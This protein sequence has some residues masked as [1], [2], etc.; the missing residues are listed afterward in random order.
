MDKTRD[1]KLYA[2]HPHSCS[3]LPDHEAT[4]V[5]VDP[6]LSIDREIYSQLS[7]FGFRR[8]GEHLY[9][10]RCQSCQACIAARIPVDFFTPNRQQ[11]RCW[12]RNQ[13]IQVEL[14]STIF[15]D[16]HYQLYA[17]YISGRHA[18]GDMYPPTRHQYE[19]FLMPA[20][21]STRY[22]EMRLE[23]KLLGV[24][25]CDFM[26]NGVSAVYTFFDPLADK[27]G[28]G[29]FAVLY[30]VELARQHGLSSVYLGYWIKDCAKM[31]YKSQ[32]RPLELFIS[33]RWIRLN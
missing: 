30:Q 5:F 2:T 26:D 14:V 25:V 9:R 15:T 33:N 23:G 31:N 16:E 11:R 3:Y 22:I 4:S 20:W 32:Y 27:R 21:E 8:S 19:S 7:E 17:S 12:K 1:I 29:M 24:G 18:D 6:D 10:P 28:L 13:D